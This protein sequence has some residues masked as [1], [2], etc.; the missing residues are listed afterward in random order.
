MSSECTTLSGI[1]ILQG[2][3][4]RASERRYPLQAARTMMCR[5]VTGMGSEGTVGERVYDAVVT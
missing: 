2:D 5:C 4:G 1:G 3:E